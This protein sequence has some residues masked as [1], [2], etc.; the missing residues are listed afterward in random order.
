MSSSNLFYHLRVGYRSDY[1]LH[2]SCNFNFCDWFYKH[3]SSK[4]SVSSQIETQILMNKM[5]NKL[6]KSI[7]LHVKPP[8][9]QTRWDVQKNDGFKIVN[10]ELFKLLVECIFSVFINKNVYDIF[11]QPNVL[12]SLTC[13][14]RSF[15][16]S[17]ITL[18]D[19]LKYNFM[20]AIMS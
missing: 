9:F 17:G 14:T 11:W 19:K 2:F 16:T 12:T 5:C 20:F 1:T 6:N 8:T 10:I 13:L 3:T 18:L 15:H 4:Q 7:L